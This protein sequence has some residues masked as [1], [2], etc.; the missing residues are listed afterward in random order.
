MHYGRQVCI[1]PPAARDPK[2][3]TARSK[4]RT[5]SLVLRAQLFNMLLEAAANRQRPVIEMKIVELRDALSVP[6]GKLAPWK[7]L[8]EF[9][10]DPALKEIND[11]STAA[12]FS[13]ECEPITA[14]S[15]ETPKIY[16]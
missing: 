10:I 15:N 12:G 14:S 6:D 16:A 8:R 11:N 3:S 2:R 7:H 5:T 9:A 1:V 13:V 4:R